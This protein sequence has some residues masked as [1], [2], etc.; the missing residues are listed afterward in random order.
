MNIFEHLRAKRT[1]GDATP[2]E[3]KLS[4]KRMALA[5]VVTIVFGMIYFYFMLP[6]INLHDPGFYAFVF[7]MA[8]VF[9]I[10]CLVGNMHAVNDARSFFTVIRRVC[11]IP[12]A[13][14]ALLVVIYL[15]GTLLG[16]PILRA[17]AYRDL[18]TIQTGDFTQEVEQISYDEIPMLDKASAER[19]GDRKLGELADMVSQFEVVDDYNQINYKGRPVRVATLQYGDI[20]KW[21]ANQAD[22]LPAY[23]V[24]DMV[25][26]NVEVVRLQEGIKYSLA[27]HFGRN[28]YRHLRFQYPTFMFDT[29][30]FEIDDDGYPWWVCPRIVKRIGLFGGTDV[31]G[32]VLVDAITGESTYYEEVPTW[33]DQV[34]SADLIV[35]QYDYHGMYQNGFLNSLFGQRDV[36]ATTSGYNYIAMDDDVYV[37]TGITSVTGDQSNIGF[38]LTNQRTKETRYYTC[39][40]AD[41]NSAMASAEGYVQNLKY[42]ATFPLLLNVADQPTYFIA[43][44]DNAGLVKMYAMVN[45]QQYNIVATAATVEECEAKYGQLLMENN[46]T[47]QPTPSLNEVQGTVAEIRTAVIDG[48]TTYYFR[49]EGETAYYAVSAQSCEAAVA[50]NVGDAVKI[51]SSSAEGE[52][53]LASTIQRTQ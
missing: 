11:A 42:E 49:L 45:V 8:A 9:C 20:F 12:A 24:I 38:I 40:G 50:I 33:V 4:G 25:T 52:I 19:L 41:E 28:L 13:I 22:G 18:M 31:Q 3:A 32:A 39:A 36:T 30:H 47:D 5:A 21:F 51:T 29:P 17:G 46:I 27:D 35:Q 1:V 23:I 37:Y 44:K 43:L 6:A 14:C 34:Y 15:V 48:Y 7:L 16:S 2:V 10:V 26:Q 53:R